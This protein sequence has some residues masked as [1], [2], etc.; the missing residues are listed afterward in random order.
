MHNLYFTIGISKCGKSTWC[1]SI[2]SKLPNTVLVSLDTI[3]EALPNESAHEKAFFLIN[4]ELK[5]HNVLFDANN[6]VAAHRYH[7]LTHLDCYRY[8][9]VYGILFD[10]SL[11]ESISNLAKYNS[12]GEKAYVTEEIITRQYVEYCNDITILSSFQPIS[13]SQFENKFI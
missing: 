6:C 1:N 13:K 9:N 11:Q 12:L 4:H 2:I 5:T 3:K 8:D 10:V 7:L